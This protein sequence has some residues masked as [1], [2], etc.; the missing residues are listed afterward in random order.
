ML[1]QLNKENRKLKNG[2]EKRKK[3]IESMNPEWKDLSKSY[4]KKISQSNNESTLFRNDNL[5]VTGL[6]IAAGLS[7]RMGDFKPLIKHNGKSFIMN[8]LEKMGTVCDHVIV[9]T[10]HKSDEISSHINKNQ[11][12][13]ETNINLICNIDYENGMFSS[14]K[15]G[16][17]K[18]KKSDWILYHMVDQPNLPQNFY[19]NFVNQINSSYNWIQPTI[20][21]RK[22]HPILLDSFVSN[23]IENASYKD[24]LRDISNNKEIRKKYWNCDYKEIFTDI[25]TPNDLSNILNQV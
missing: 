14:I 21:S 8:I 23:K 6:L 15:C 1:I 24:S 22:G 25:D 3:L 12:K 13:I 16:I 19:I 5:L 20:N 10:G 7:S 2:G 18:I 9:V 11:K 17:N 4:G